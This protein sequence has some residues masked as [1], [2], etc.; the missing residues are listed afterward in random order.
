MPSTQDR[1]EPWDPRVTYVVGHQRPDTDAIAGALG[2]AWFLSA[3]GEGP[4]DGPFVAARCGKPTDQA[5]F[6]LERFK[7][8]PPRYLRAVAPT[9]GHA[10]RPHAA[11]NP[12]APLS[13]AMTQLALGQRVVPVLDGEEKPLGVVTPMAIARAYSGPGGG[14]EAF[15]QPCKNVLEALPTFPARERIGDHRAALLRSDADDFLV[16]DEAG[17]YVGVASRARVREPPRA[18]LILVDHNELS[19]AVPGA[20]E[21]EIIAVLDH[22][23]LGNPATAAPIP[24]VVEPVGSTSTLVAELC[25]THGLTPPPGIVGMLLSGLLSDTLILRSPTSTERDRQVME[26]LGQLLEVDPAAYGDE[27]LR[28]APGLA[29]REVADVMEGDRKRYEIGGNSISVAQV[30]VTSFHELPQRAAD[31]LAA[32]QQQ[33]QQE[34]LALACLMVTDVITGRSRLLVQGEPRLVA[35]LPFSHLDECLFDLGDFVSRKKQL[36][37]A[38]YDVLAEAG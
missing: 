6:A 36:V 25:R 35:A 4:E 24:F 33:R 17:S 37:P 19:Q 34:G 28:A 29:T 10:A 31:L 16:V 14:P 11:V 20:D 3:S 15:A 32:L 13:D 22:H 38:L 1:Y 23:R 18:K 9:F 2:Y 26:W 12:D 7:Q 27:L 8:A 5:L 30:E 21:A